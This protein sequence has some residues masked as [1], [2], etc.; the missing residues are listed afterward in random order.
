MRLGLIVND[1]RPE[2]LDF[3]R[4]LVD[5]CGRLGIECTSNFDVLGLD[6]LK[7]PDVLAAIGGDGTVLEAVGL[8]LALDRPLIGFNL[9]TLGFLADAEPEDM[10]PVLRRLLS[11]DFQ[12]LERPTLKASL[13]GMTALGVNDVVVEKI[14]SQRLVVLD[15]SIDG[16][17]FLTYRVDGIV[18]ATATGSTAYA[19][20]AGGPLVDPR[21]E[22]LLVV[23]VAPHSLFGRPVLLPAH[24]IVECRVAANRPVRVSVDGRQV[25]TLDEMS[26]LTIGSGEKRARFIRFDDEP[27]ASRLTRK[28]GLT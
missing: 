17:E 18:F 2:A 11:G 12:V 5:E 20:S 10:E 7:E 3:A 8:G 28:F 13:D 19:F 4:R 27:F 24:S 23:P 22:A 6:P 1:N 26:S 21:I 9:G 16:Q 15:V 25:G 14:D